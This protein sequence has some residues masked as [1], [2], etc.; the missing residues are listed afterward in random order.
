M[1]SPSVAGAVATVLISVVLDPGLVEAETAAATG[2]RVG[3]SSLALRVF[4]ECGVETRGDLCGGERPAVGT[5][6][7]FSSSCPRISTSS[8]GA[9]AGAGAGAGEGLSGSG[10][11]FG[12]CDSAAAPAAWGALVCGEP[13]VADSD[14]CSWPVELG[15]LIDSPRSLVGKYTGISFS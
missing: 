2:A 4:S 14:C 8:A 1:L 7:G 5:S 12:E 11:T 9:V 3:M 10:G 6:I 13:A 15:G